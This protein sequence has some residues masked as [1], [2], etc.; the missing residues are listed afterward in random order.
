M[1]YVLN[2]LPVS[3][4]AKL[5]QVENDCVNLKLGHLYFKKNYLDDVR[6]MTLRNPKL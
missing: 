1:H 3:S 4:G 2:Q 5:P 6:S